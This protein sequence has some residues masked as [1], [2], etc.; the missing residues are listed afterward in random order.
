VFP[1][2]KERALFRQWLDA[3]PEDRPQSLKINTPEGIRTLLWH[4]SEIR[5]A[6]H[7]EFGL[8]W[9]RA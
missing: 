7:R 6:E 1:H 2:D 5:H 4:A 9:T 3:E 8:L